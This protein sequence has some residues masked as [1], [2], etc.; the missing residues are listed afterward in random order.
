MFKLD[1]SCRDKS[2]LLADHSG[3]STSIV[4]LYYSPVLAPAEDTK[5]RLHAGI[6]LESL[7]I[8]GSLS[9]AQ[10]CL[11]SHIGHRFLKFENLHS[12]EFSSCSV[13]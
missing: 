10:S 8:T 2:L 13:S 12:C 7:N 1:K 9:S 11:W 5:A 3:P 4:R 6:S